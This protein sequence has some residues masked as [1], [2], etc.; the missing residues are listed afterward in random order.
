MV[1][2]ACHEM[3]RVGDGIVQFADT[4]LAA[5]EVCREL[6]HDPGKCAQLGKAGYSKALEY[7][8]EVLAR[9]FIEVINKV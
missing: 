4:G 1:A 5:A 3:Q 6:L 9:K 8:Y 7:N 2:T